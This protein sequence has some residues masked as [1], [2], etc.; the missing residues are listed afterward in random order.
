[1]PKAYWINA[2]REINNTDALAEYAKLAGPSIQAAGGRFLVRGMPAA[3]KEHGLMQRTVVVEFDSL[4]TA[5]ATYSTPGY[6]AAL[7]ALGN[8]A[9]VRDMRI[10]EGV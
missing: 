10:I 6:Q 9:V 5:L 1:M 2:Y 7:K 3:V 4:E 8:N